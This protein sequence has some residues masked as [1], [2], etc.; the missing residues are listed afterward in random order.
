YW[1]REHGTQGMFRVDDPSPIG[2]PENPPALAA[3]FSVEVNGDSFTVERPVVYKWTDPARGERYRPFEIVPAVTVEFDAKTLLF[4][5]ANPRHV[6]A[7]PPPRP[8]PP[9][10]P[11]PPPPPP[12]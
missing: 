7:P 3:S 4:P 6:A 1:L 12:T 5:D 2:M 8:P 9:P 10:P 11:R